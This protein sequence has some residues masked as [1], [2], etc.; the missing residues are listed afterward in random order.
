MVVID[1]IYTTVSETLVPVKTAS[2]SD[3]DNFC[4][5]VRGISSYIY[6]YLLS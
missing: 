4:G 2:T 6:I 1:L 3:V 5:Y